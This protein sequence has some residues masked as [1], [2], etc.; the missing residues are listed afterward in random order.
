MNLQHNFFDI[1]SQKR[2][3]DSKREQQKRAI[4]QN[5]TRDIIPKRCNESI[6]NKSAA[7]SSAFPPVR[8]H[9]LAITQFALNSEENSS[10][11][12]STQQPNNY[13]KY[14]SSKQMYKNGK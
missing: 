4:I 11:S 10:T 2:K 14:T 12:D 1:I 7:L 13:Y 9:R 6:Q 5:L 3:S 8:P